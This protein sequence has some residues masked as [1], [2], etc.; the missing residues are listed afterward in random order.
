M[1]IYLYVYKE[2]KKQLQGQPTGRELSFWGFFPYLLWSLHPSK[3]EPGNLSDNN[4][5]AESVISW[6]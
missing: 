3:P 2:N 4:N 6:Y 1:Y 5:N